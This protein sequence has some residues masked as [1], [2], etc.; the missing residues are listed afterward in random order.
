MLHL[1]PANDVLC[2]EIY[3]P[4]TFAGYIIILQIV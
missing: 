2:T 4:I 3:A 1:L